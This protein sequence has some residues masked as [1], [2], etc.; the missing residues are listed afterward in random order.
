MW[1]LFVKELCVKSLA[2]VMAVENS[3]ALARGARFSF[4]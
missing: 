2:H 4:V 3:V 1:K